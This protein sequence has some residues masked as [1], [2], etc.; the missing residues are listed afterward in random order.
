MRDFFIGWAKALSTEGA[1]AIKHVM[2]ICVVAFAIMALS[3]VFAYKKA[4]DNII[5]YASKKSGINLMRELK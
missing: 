1:R 2:I 5:G 3:G 4:Q